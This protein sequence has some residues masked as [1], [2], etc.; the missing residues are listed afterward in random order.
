MVINTNYEE[1][2]KTFCTSKAQIGNWVTRKKINPTDLISICEFYYD[3]YK[4][5]AKRS[6]YWDKQFYY[7]KQHV[8]GGKER[9]AMENRLR[10]WG[11]S[12][13]IYKL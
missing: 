5:I 2:A 8:L 9:K 7:Y 3:T 4:K 10:D 12:K 6:A 11:R 1:L 13:E